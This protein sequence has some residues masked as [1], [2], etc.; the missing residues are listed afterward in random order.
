ML[1]DFSLPVERGELIALLGASGCG[2]TTVLRVIAGLLR[3]DAGEVL[4]HGKDITN[5]AA[6][7]RRAAMVF[8][9]PLLFPFLNVE[10]NVGFGLKM[11]N[12]AKAEIADKTAE[13]LRLVRLENFS[14][15][16]PR[17]LSGGQEQ[18][19]ALARA[20][21]TEP[22]V[23]LLDE[24]FSALDAGLRAEM[25]NFVRELQRRLKIT[26]VF[27]THDQEE[28]VAVADR[29]AFVDDGNLAQIAEPKMFFTK[30][31]TPNVARFFGWKVF[32]GSICGDVVETSIGN[33]DLSGSNNI[34]GESKLIQVGF[35]PDWVQVIPPNQN[36][37]NRNYPGGTLEQKINLGARLRLSLRLK[38]DE[39]MEIDI[40]DS[41]AI[42][43]FTAV[44]CKTEVTF[45]IPSESLVLF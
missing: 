17:Q 26:T 39:I 35:H 14:H 19:V 28:A 1:Q 32:E 25:R 3:A 10:E 27:V 40:V 37:Q 8:Q 33:F 44:E 22:R 18:R 20:L 13:A 36:G 4:L 29:I 31:A 41:T 5:V 30:P 42:D 15:R 38:N 12:I 6:E 21:I 23:L 34:S 16:L 45:F 24:P 7:K 2:K 11:Q 9:K 43:C